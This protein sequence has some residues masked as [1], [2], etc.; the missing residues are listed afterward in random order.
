MFRGRMESD[1]DINENWFYVESYGP[2][3]VWGTYSWNDS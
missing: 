1:L 2:K 3:R